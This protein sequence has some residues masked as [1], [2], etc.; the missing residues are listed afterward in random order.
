MVSMFLMPVV[1]TPC[2]RQQRE[3]GE[4]DHQAQFPAVHHEQPGA[5][6]RPH[7]QHQGEGKVVHGGANL[8]DAGVAGGQ[9]TG[10]ETVDGIHGQFEQ[11]DHVAG[12]RVDAQ[13]GELPLAQGVQQQPHHQF[14]YKE[15][16][17]ENHQGREPLRVLLRDDVVREN[18]LKERRQHMGGHVPDQQQERDSEKAHAA[19]HEAQDQ[20]HCAVVFHSRRSF[21]ARKR[22]R[23]ES[24]R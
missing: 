20:G 13:L 4:N 22:V 21:T 2:N 10:R 14:Q 17:V 15:Q 23:A 24:N 19:P 12:R 11:A 9:L 6:D 16:D 3:H 5:E 18:L 8:L 7:H 1:V